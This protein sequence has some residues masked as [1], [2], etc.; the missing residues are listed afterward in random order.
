MTLLVEG[1]G[2]LLIARSRWFLLV[3]RP[4]PDQVTLASQDRQA[5]VARV[6]R[7]SFRAATE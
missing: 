6:G 4:I 3:R 1:L 5:G 7:V 2:P